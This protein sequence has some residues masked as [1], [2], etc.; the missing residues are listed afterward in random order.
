[1]PDL[2]RTPNEIK[3]TI[4]SIF[5]KVLEESKLSLDI[6]KLLWFKH[7]LIEEISYKIFGLLCEE[8]R[9]CLEIE[10]LKHEDFIKKQIVNYFKF[11]EQK[12][13]EQSDLI[14]NWLLEIYDINVS[15]LK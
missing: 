1:M 10:K 15:E 8:E 11:K 9:S 6:P 5:L 2:I 4:N 14:R 3:T 13:Y 7:L 12:K